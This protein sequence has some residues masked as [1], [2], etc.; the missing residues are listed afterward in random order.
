MHT[1]ESFESLS[2]VNGFKLGHLNVRSLLKK[3][4]QIRLLLEDTQLDILKITETWVKPYAH[5]DLIT[6]KD[7][8]AF[9]LDRNVNRGRNKR[10]G[11]L[12]TY[13]NVKHASDCELLSDLNNSDENVEA[14]WTYICRPYCKDVMICNIYRAPAGD[15]QKAITYLEDCLKTVNMCRQMFSC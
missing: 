6:I 10:G 7:F 8:R 3:I 11:G 4:D 2:K 13:V 9:R 5:S 12:I 1:P 14:Q 15:L